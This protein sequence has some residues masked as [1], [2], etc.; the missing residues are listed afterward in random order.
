MLGIGGGASAAK[1]EEKQAADANKGGRLLGF[2]NNLSKKVNEIKAKGLESSSSM[3]AQA[4]MA[5][6]FM[7]PN[8]NAMS[9]LRDKANAGGQITKNRAA[10]LAIAGMPSGANSK[11]MQE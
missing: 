4:M 2:S 9:S 3:T 7:T 6:G 5:K 1:E 8:V 10:L 11:Q